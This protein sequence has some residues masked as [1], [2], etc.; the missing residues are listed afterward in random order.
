MDPTEAV[1]V[2]VPVRNGEAFLGQALDS[3]LIQ[4]HEPLEI[5]VVDNGSTDGSADV[6]RSYGGTVR[7]L[8]SSP[9]G[10]ARA[11][12]TAVRASRYPWLAFLDHD[13]L[14][15]AGKLQRQLGE[16]RRLPELDAVYGHAVNFTGIAP[17]TYKPPAGAAQPAPVPGTLLIRREAFNRV[18]ELDEDRLELA[19]FHR[20]MASE[21]ETQWRCNRSPGKSLLDLPQTQCSRHPRRS[22]C[23]RSHQL[24]KQAHIFAPTD[25]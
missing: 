12:N 8:E 15:V 6:A 14:W 21:A 1:S 20:G 7:C 23:S 16:I 2:I 3:I 22:S 25:S 5:L 11:I 9:P 19:A 18:G 17:S 13:D 4:D 24:P 10:Q